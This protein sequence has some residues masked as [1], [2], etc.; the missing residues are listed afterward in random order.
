VVDVSNPSLPRV[1]GS[2]DTG[3]EGNGIAAGSCQIF[4]ADG[5]AG[6]QIIPMQCPCAT[7]VLL[8]DLAATPQS[9][10]ILLSWRTG[11]EFAAFDVDRAVIADGRP[12]AFVELNTLQ[13]SAARDRWEYLDRSA[14][15]GKTYAYRIEGHLRGGARVAF[16]PILAS[17]TPGTEF[18]LARPRPFPAYESAT[19]TLS[20]PRRESVR[21]DVY[22]VAGRRARTLLAEV[23]EA[24]E[25]GITWDTRDDTGRPVAS[26]IYLVRL[27]WPGGSR[28]TR[29]AVVR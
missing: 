10:G 3:G 1:I 9:D 21:L 8:F 25:H 22:D 18:A 19:I 15:S 23:R 24:G 6:L 11:P 20:L 7:P 26:G 28:T 12:D 13:A 4:V 2:I 14:A 5:P 29:A 27:G 16:G 17:R